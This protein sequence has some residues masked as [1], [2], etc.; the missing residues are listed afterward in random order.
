[1]STH[2]VVIVLLPAKV[3]LWEH[4]V[5]NTCAVYER[6][7]CGRCVG[8]VHFLSYHSIFYGIIKFKDAF[9]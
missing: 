4:N 7:A 5:N 2:L 9:L 3:L 1:M 8:L 6:V